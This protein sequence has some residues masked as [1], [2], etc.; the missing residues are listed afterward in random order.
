MSLDYLRAVFASTE[1]G[2]YERL[3]MLA[4]ADRADDS[5]TCYPSMPDICQRTGMGERGVQNVIKRLVSD[6]HLAVEWGGGKHR[7]NTYK[8]HVNPARDAGYD[9]IPRTEN[10]VSDAGFGGDTPHPIT[11][12]P[13]PITSYPAP[14][15]GEPSI[16]IIE[17]RK[18]PLCISPSEKIPRRR[19]EV[20]LPDGWVPS[21]RNIS[22]ARSK[23]F[24]DAEISENADAFRNHH[25]A[26][27]NRYRDW[28]AAWRTWLGNARKFSAPRHAGA[29]GGHAAL[30]AGFHRVA[31]GI[32]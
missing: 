22:D 3:V 27:G 14:D 26:R 11:D 28:D 29:S 13:H 20:P 1:L 16:T 24:T 6:G 19:P 4:L 8:L 23:N 21:E 12:T 15:A 9:A 18:E 10:A 2:P 32:N 25:H 17:P 31:S 7:R 5:G 30:F